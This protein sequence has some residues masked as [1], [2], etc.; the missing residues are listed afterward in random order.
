MKRL[1]ASL[2]LAPLFLA[3]SAFADTL[4]E[5]LAAAYRNNPNIEDAR[6][7]VRS[8]R[9]DSVQAFS[10]YLPG[11]GLN[12]SY[13][14]RHTDSQT[15]GFFGPQST[16]SQLAPITG[17]VQLQQQLYTGGRRSGEVQRARAGVEGARHNLRGTEQDILLAAID[18]YLSVRRDAEIVR[19]RIDHVSGLER[20]VNGVR[21]RLEVGEVSRTDVAQA[22]TRLA[23]ARAALARA[24]A[25]LESSRARY[26][27]VV[28]HAPETL[29]PAPIPEAPASLDNAVR[30][31]EARHPDILQAMADRRAARAQ[32]RVEQ[33]GLRP[34][35]SIAGRYEYAEESSQENDRLEGA[36]A[37][38]QLSVPL[39]EG[40]FT[41]SRT[42]QSRINVE[43][44]SARIE[45]A[46]RE[47]VANVIA[48]WNNLEAGRDIVAAAREQVEAADSAL[49]GA[50]RERGL[51]L[52]STIDVL[53]AE[54]E[55]RDAL[56]ALAR[57]DAEAAFAA[58]R[59]LAATGQ[60]TVNVLG[61]KE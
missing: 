60:L 10:N 40:G 17:S 11:V 3:P 25:E 52:R 7:A 19:L 46:R 56:I 16:Q 37:V 30:E 13:G 31:A 21:R 59:L 6:L 1:L 58:F 57:A 38:A 9:E 54:E 20:Q 23:G 45:A 50:E 49:Q 4:E 61:L 18:A 41:R 39:Y 32:V 53:N 24:E 43:R 29:A 28:G 15:T 42:R 2:S 35:V 8:A 44:A 22:Q 36:S 5:A 26:E 14:V 48:S 12:A 34:Q 27:L 55:R 47:V 33:S 51:G